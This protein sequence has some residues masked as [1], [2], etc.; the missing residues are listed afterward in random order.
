MQA[1]SSNVDRA[2]DARRHA[3][4]DT[5]RNAFLPSP[6]PEPL[7]A[8][9]YNWQRTLS[10]SEF[11]ATF[12][13]Y[14]QD[15]NILIGTI[16]SFNLGPDINGSQVRMS[17]TMSR[18]A[19]EE[20]KEKSHSSNQEELHAAIQAELKHLSRIVAP[21]DDP[22]GRSRTENDDLYRWNIWTLRFPRPDLDELAQRGVLFIG[23]AAHAM[24]IFAGEVSIAS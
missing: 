7:A 13:Q 6:Q 24:P 20:D 22:V 15:T 21:Y 2:R 10:R 8:V 18:P 14:F 3:D 11:D 23:D 5:V 17:F 16:Q 12:G 19:R 4:N 9:V 1:S